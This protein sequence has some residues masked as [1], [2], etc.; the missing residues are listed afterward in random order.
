MADL[1]ELEPYLG[2]LPQLK[3][4]LLTCNTETSRWWVEL[5]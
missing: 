3:L 4:G 1:I 5:A 2:V